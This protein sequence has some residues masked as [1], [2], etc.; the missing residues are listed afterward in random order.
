[1]FSYKTLR[2]LQSGARFYTLANVVASL[3]VGLAAAF[4]GLGLAHA[5]L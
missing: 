2:L 4:G 5:V 1:M 3:V